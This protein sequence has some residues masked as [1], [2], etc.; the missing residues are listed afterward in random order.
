MLFVNDLKSA[1]ALALDL[2][3]HCIGDEAEALFKDQSANAE[4]L[5]KMPGDETLK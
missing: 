1:E 4:Q 5:G 2:V 3:N